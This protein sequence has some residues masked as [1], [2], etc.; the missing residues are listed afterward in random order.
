MA[1]DGAPVADV[2]LD[3]PSG[4]AEVEGGEQGAPVSLEVPQLE[5][6][7]SAMASVDANALLNTLREVEMTLVDFHEKSSELPS[8]ASSLVP[9]LANLERIMQRYGANMGKASGAKD[10]HHTLASMDVVE[11]ENKVLESVRKETTEEISTAKY[12]LDGK[13]EN[14][15]REMER[16]QLLLKTRPNQKEVHKILEVVTDL[17]LD[18]RKTMSDATR[19]VDGMVTK[20]VT[21]EME[22]MAGRIGMS[23]KSLDASFNIANKKI[24]AFNASLKEFESGIDETNKKM[25]GRL[26]QQQASGDLVAATLAQFKDEH[27][28]ERA[29]LEK[30]RV[31]MSV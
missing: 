27:E 16:L 15:V 13:V 1:D 6:H 18:V 26:D 3:Q 25:N 23:E 30:V 31:S 2:P 19:L 5:P 29:R 4:E 22:T 12:I 9:R 8:W 10:E 14:A 21:T 7:V 24:T 17:G 20:T 28:Q 11:V